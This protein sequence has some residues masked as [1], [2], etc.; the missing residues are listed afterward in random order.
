MSAVRIWFC[1]WSVWSVWMELSMSPLSLPER[2]WLL[3]LWTIALPSVIWP[4]KPVERTVFSLWMIRRWNILR[5]ILRRN[6]ISMR[7]MR[8]RSMTES[9][10]L[11]FLP[12]SPQWLF[13][14]CRKIPMKSAAL[15]RLLLIRRSSVPVP[16]ADFPIS[17]WLLRLPREERLR[18]TFVASWFLPPRRF[19]WRLWRRAILR[20]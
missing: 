14:I 2:V 3:F 20:I 12:L 15:I 16:T 10:R 9:S 7:Q 1:I 18:K 13:P 4:L 17:R 5:L 6:I 11:T 19:I 8:M